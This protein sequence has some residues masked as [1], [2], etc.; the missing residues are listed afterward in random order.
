MLNGYFYLGL[1]K[2]A[3]VLQDV[4]TNNAARIGAEA[5]DY[6]QAIHRVLKECVAISP[7]TRLRDNTGVPTVPSY[8]G[9]RGFS[10]DVKD[11]VDPDARHAY[12]YDSTLG[13]L[14]LLKSEV[15]E[16]V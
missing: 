6:L 1:K 16:L 15:V 2:S 10:S 9:L 8:L 13:P 7:V 5:E 3:I 12:V 14:H 11:S 4:D